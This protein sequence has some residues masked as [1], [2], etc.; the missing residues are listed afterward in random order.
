[1]IKMDLLK[2]TVKVVISIFVLI[3]I[4]ELVVLTGRYEQSLL[5]SPAG[6]LTGMAELIK[7]GA[8]LTHFKVS[9]VR[10][11]IGYLAAVITG[12]TLGLMLGWNKS[13]WSFIDPVVQVL[14]PVSP[15]AWFPFIVLWFGIGDAPAVVTIFIAGFYPILLST[16]SGVGNVDTVYL[17]VADNFGIRQ[18]QLL[19]KI[20]LPAAFPLIANSLHIALGSAWVFLVAGEMVGAQSGLGFMI[21]DARNSL[22]S[23]LVLAGIIFI[24][25]SGLL[26]DRLIKILESGIKRQW[27]V[28]IEVRN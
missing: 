10:F 23:D 1:V 8:L 12:I 14:R 21:I 27:G 18:P 2:K 28:S 6:V 24:G 25:I 26:L 9:L 3:G 15:I 17:K 7:D 13:V 20:I 19:F 11:L 4:W 22:R 5:P 16:V